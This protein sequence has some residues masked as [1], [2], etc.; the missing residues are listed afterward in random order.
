MIS[1]KS[2]SRVQRAAVCFLLL[3]LSACVT[4]PKE[5]TPPPEPPPVQA[6]PSEPVI[7]VVGLQRYLKLER[8]LEDLGF[9]EKAFNTCRVGY[10]Y[11][12]SSNCRTL[13]LAV[14]SFRLQ[15]RDSEGTVSSALGAADLQ[16]LAGREIGWV[17]K[18]YSGVVRTDGQGYAQILTISPESARNQRL[19]LGAGTQFLYIKAGELTRVVTP[20]PW[21]DQ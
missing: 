4:R 5:E 18:S 11:S 12:S 1:M 7:D 17:L 10:G 21:C 16:P 15:C 13:F 20:R 8:E 3:S 6:E 2:S 19:R 9:Q 14:V